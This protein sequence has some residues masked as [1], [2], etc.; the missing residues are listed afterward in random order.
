MMFLQY[1]I[2]LGGKCVIISFESSCH[3]LVGAFDVASV[4]GFILHVASARHHQNT[5]II[6]LPSFLKARLE[7]VLNNF[8]AR[9]GTTHR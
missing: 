3:A 8:D 5:T 9:I 1:E 7:R 4:F 6:V 2:V